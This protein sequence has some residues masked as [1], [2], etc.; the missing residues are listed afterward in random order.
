MT[1]PL[2][3]FAIT[4]FN[5]EAYIGECIESVLRQSV[6]D[7]YEIIIVDD[8]STDNSADVIR[9]FHDPRIRYTRQTHQRGEAFTVNAALSAT[10]GAYIARVDGDDRLRPDFLERTLPILERFPEVGLVYGDCARINAQGEVVQDPWSGLPTRA[11][12]GGR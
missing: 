2:V 11:V 10:R 8:A 4:C 7:D 9:S 1:N 6:T 12:H 3:S 5:L